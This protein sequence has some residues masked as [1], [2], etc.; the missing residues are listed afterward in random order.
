MEQPMKLTRRAVI[1][2]GYA[3]NLN[4]RFCYYKYKTKKRWK[5]LSLVKFE[6][7]I[8]RYVFGNI[9]VDITG[10]EPTIYPHIIEFV[11]Y[12]KAIG[13]RPTLITNGI[14]LANKKKV[15]KLKSAGVF[16]Y[17]ISVHGIGKVYDYLVDLPNAFKAQKKG[18]ENLITEGI[19]I[20][21]NVTINNLNTPQLPKIAEYAIKK[22]VKVV[23][24]ICF[25]PFYEWEKIYGIDFQEKHSIIAPYL[26]KAIKKLGRHKIEANVRYYPICFLKGLEKHQYNYSQL[27]YDSHEWDFMS[28]FKR[29]SPRYNL[30]FFFNKFRL[31]KYHQA[32]KKYY[33]EQ[34]LIVKKRN[35]KKEKKCLNCSLTT[36]CDG[37]TKQYYHRFGDS[38]MRPYKG[39]KITDPTHFIKKQFKVK[40]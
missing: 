33:M 22:N 34:S 8:Y 3:C 14:V 37:P 40:D 9:K 29:K 27:P 16:D 38:E 12:C 20:R 5:P 4:C 2:I 23:N 11:K 26:V 6:A 24:F 18:I 30:F 21:V 25:N 28:W 19:N 17:L 10:G 15:K 35:Y 1:Y 32:P 36:I 7:F 31:R 39:E 13:L